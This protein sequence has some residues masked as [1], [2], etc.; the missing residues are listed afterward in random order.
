M[1]TGQNY[2]LFSCRP[3]VAQVCLTKVTEAPPC[4][5]D[6]DC[7][8]KLCTRGMK[9]LAMRTALATTL[10][11][12]HPAQIFNKSQ[13][14]EIA[15]SETETRAL[16]PR[17]PDDER[18]SLVCALSEAPWEAIMDPGVSENDFGYMGGSINAGPK[19]GPN[20]LTMIP[21][22]RTPKQGP[23]VLGQT[24]SRH[25]L[26]SATWSRKAWGPKDCISN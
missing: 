5:S 25:S 16:A 4:S 9:F 3:C 15:R 10:A 20:I 24:F 19:M 8:C 26:R 1:A 11:R 21:I 7:H 14:Q 13:V 18:Q 22:I 23:Q 17:T 6:T 12:S 2:Q